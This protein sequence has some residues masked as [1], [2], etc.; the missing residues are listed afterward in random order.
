MG[1]LTDKIKCPDCGST[2]VSKFYCTSELVIYCQNGL[3]KGFHA[4]K[5]TYSLSKGVGKTFVKVHW[6]YQCPDESFSTSV[7][8]NCQN[9]NCNRPLKGNNQKY[10]SIKCKSLT[11]RKNNRNRIE[12]V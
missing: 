5:T 11:I 4:Y 1:K 2:R 10:C 12:V 6:D 9:L 7:Y 8:L 3:H